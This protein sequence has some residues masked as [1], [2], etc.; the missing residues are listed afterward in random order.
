MRRAASRMICFTLWLLVPLSLTA[1]TAAGQGLDLESMTCGQ[2]S[3]LS[4][5][6]VQT[7]V[8]GLSV[9]YAMGQEGA[10]F[11][12]EVANDWFAA[13]RDFCKLAPD[14]KVTEV[15]A[16]LSEQTEAR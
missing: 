11:E 4:P 12:L 15:M 10:A 13:F 6:S 1:Q 8:I 9:G 2:L 5:D 14:T 16:V 3:R 7:S